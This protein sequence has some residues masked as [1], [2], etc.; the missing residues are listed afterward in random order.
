MNLHTFQ[1]GGE[2]IA[3]ITLFGDNRNS[4]VLL[5]HRRVMV[6]YFDIPVNYIRCPFPSVSHGQMMDEALRLTVDIPDAPDYYWWFDNDALILR[7]ATIDAMYETVKNK[8]TVWGQ[9]W[10][11]SHLLGPNGS[12][13]HPYASQACLCFSRSLYNALG[14]PSCNHNTRADTAEEITY[15]AEL[16]G[17]VV[18][19]SY[20]SHS[21]T[22][23][24]ALGNGC[25]YGRGNVY[26]KPP[27]SYHES[28]TD[29]DGHVERFTAMAKRVLAGEF[30][31]ANL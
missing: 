16:Q 6:D 14:R 8:Q 2:S 13:Q 18:A 19:L 22:Q 28:R 10:Q 5:W 11:S 29:L 3:C 9:A 15:Q 21:D 7:A 12:A 17:F 1:R 4:E 31:I 25:T 27:M 24:T 20:P 30:E 26:G 23:T